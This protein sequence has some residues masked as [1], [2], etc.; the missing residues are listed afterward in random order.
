MNLFRHWA[1]SDSI[2]P[3]MAFPIGDVHLRG[4]TAERTDRI[5]A[6]MLGSNHFADKLAKVDGPKRVGMPVV[7]AL[8]NKFE[9]DQMITGPRNIARVAFEDT[10]I[11]PERRRLERYD[12]LVCMSQW[13]ADLLRSCSDRPVHVAPEAVDH[14]LFFPQPK[15]GLSSK[16]RF[17]IFT[18]GKIEFR[19]AQ[20]LVLLAFREFSR[21]HDDAVLVAAWRSP[22]PEYSAGFQGRLKAPVGL[23]ADGELDLA[24]WLAANDIDPDRFVDLG[25]MPN[26]AMPNI[27]RDMDCALLPSRAEGGTNLVAMEAMAC[28]VPAILARNAGVADIALDDNCIA[29]TDQGPVAPPSGCG[30]SG[31]GES[32]IDEMVAALERLHASAALRRQVGAAGAAFMK[33]RT[34]AGHAL[35]LERLALAR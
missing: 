30:T 11:G 29:L 34:W 31:W 23:A 19:K 21:R 6:S 18:G 15:S 28:G 3:L 27:L 10:E 14:E 35:A 7:H 1:V 17:Y 16:D 9:G 12:A 2:D 24:G 22:W 33:S 8:G 5:C 32:D 26:Y 25:R 20:D 13:N 4:E